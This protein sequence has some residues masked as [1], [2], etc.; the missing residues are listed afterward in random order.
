MQRVPAMVTRES[1][2][3]ALRLLLPV[4]FISIVVSNAVMVALMFEAAASGSICACALSGSFI[5]LAAK[6]KILPS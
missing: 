5:R 4:C 6:L 3:A 1:L 2:Y